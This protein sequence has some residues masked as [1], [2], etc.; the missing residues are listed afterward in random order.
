[1]NMT[2]PPAPPRLLAVDDDVS[3]AELVVRLA[4]RCRYEAFATSDSRGV[5]NLVSALNPQVIAIDVEMPNIDAFDLLEL[6]GEFNFDGNIVVISGQDLPVL[7]RVREHGKSMGL[8]EPHTMRKPI[9]TRA[10]RE[11]L[12]NSISTDQVAA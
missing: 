6:L 7:D 9:E 4:E 3:S 1:M 12:V 5:M 11:I 8:K 2:N 10:L